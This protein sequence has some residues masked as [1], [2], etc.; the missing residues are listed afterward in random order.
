MLAKCLRSETGEV[1]DPVG[2]APPPVGTGNGTNFR[3]DGA[4]RTVRS[5]GQNA[6]DED[7]PETSAMP[8]PKLPPSVLEEV[9]SSA[10]RKAITPAIAPIGND[11]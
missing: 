5:P 7:I 6:A 2:R 1:S 9:A 3:V 11:H 4:V 8:G 10:R